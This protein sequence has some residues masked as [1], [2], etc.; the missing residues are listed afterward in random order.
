MAGAVVGIIF[1]CVL[2]AS[3]LLLLELEPSHKSMHFELDQILQDLLNTEEDETGKHEFTIQSDK[4][5][6]YFI[7]DTFSKLTKNR[8]RNYTKYT[9]NDAIGNDY[10]QRSLRSGNIEFQNDVNSNDK[11]SENCHSVLC[12][13]I[14]SPYTSEVIAVIEFIRMKSEAQFTEIDVQLAQMLLRHTKIFLT[15]FMDDA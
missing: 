5:N 11:E 12:V 15:K 4:C 9:M 1:G 6:V 7:G 13:P 3:S 10:I 14:M 8:G 2:G